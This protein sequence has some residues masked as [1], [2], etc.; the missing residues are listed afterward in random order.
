LPCTALTATTIDAKAGCCGG[1]S[2]RA[3]APA[4]PDP[5]LDLAGT[6]S[7][8][9]LS[10]LLQAPVLVPGGVGADALARHRDL[11]EG[12]P[13]LAGD[14]VEAAAERGLRALDPRP[15]LAVDALRPREPHVVGGG[16]AEPEAGILAFADH[17]AV[18]HLA[19]PVV[20]H[21]LIALVVRDDG[22]DRRVV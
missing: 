14:R 22:E 6:T 15:R 20:A 3:I 11:D 5:P 21:D 7:R 10:R 9:L 19:R 2:S 4:S 17:L 12:R 18:R 8:R 1:S 13:I 16:G